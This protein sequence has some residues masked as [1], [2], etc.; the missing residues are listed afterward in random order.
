MSGTNASQ[1]SLEI[2]EQIVEAT[3]SERVDIII[4]LMEQ[5]PHGRLELP[6]REGRHADLRG[7]DLRPATLMDR[8]P[9]SRLNSADW[10][11]NQRERVILQGADLRGARL[12]EAQLQAA[13]LWGSDLRSVN[14]I[15]A[16]LTGADLWNANLASATL[17]DTVFRDA[18]LRA[19]DLRDA[20]LVDVDFR[21]AVLKHAD[22]RNARVERLDLEEA[23]L[24]GAQ[25]Q[26]LGLTD[27]NLAHVYID[28]AWLDRTRLSHTQL[29]DAIGEELDGDYANAKQG[30]LA[31]KQNF[32]SLG[33]YEAADWA[34]FK[35]RHAEKLH[36]LQRARESRAGG[37]WHA[38]GRSYMKYARDQFLEWF[39]GYGQSVAR[40]LLALLLVYV[41][42]TAI[43]ALIGGVVYV[44]TTSSGQITTADRSLIDIALFS[45]ATMTRLTSAHLRATNTFVQVLAGIEATLGL[46]LTALVGFIV[47]HRIQ[48]M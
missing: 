37:E 29:G 6:L 31:L 41:F 46:I 27:C 19:V 24:Q 28:G 35:E 47:A 17:G 18:I 44:Q 16:N 2:Y 11:D 1:A 39:F 48:R 33:D 25:L 4:D 15:D 20:S 43:Y 13:K 14:L 8:Y 45:L 21:R 36:A 9:A 26:R 32:Y 38:A 40:A 12:E 3:P 5:H 30:Y 42:F 34:Y 10:W 23:D 22:L 7:I